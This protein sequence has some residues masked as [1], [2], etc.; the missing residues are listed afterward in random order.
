[1]KVQIPKL[2]GNGNTASL[3]LQMCKTKRYDHMI[4][5]GIP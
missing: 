5:V 1:M 4:A 2:K 3:A